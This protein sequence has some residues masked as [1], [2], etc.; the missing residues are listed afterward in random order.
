VVRTDVTLG[1]GTPT[2]ANDDRREHA[3]GGRERPVRRLHS[4]TTISGST[5]RARSN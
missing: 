2:R 1:T 4:W 3:G 5:T